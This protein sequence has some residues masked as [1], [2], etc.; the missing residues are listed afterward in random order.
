MASTVDTY[1]SATKEH[2]ERAQA[3]FNEGSYFLAH[4][5]S[6]LAVE[7]HLR[8]LI[9]VKTP[10]FDSRHD[11]EGLAKE[12]RFYDIVPINESARFSAIFSTLN[13]R[14]RSNHRYFSERQFLDYMN[15]IQAEYNKGGNRWKNMAQTL[16]NH[17]YAIIKQGEA[18]WP[19]N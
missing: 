7:C 15:E 4:Y 12:A 5:L 1:R 14:W 11:L 2:L 9:R 3:S 10:N 16:L 19:K 18:K 6:G 8:A 13:R 17:A